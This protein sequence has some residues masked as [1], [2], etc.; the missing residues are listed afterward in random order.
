M[1]LYALWIYARNGAPDLPNAMT[2]NTY[3]A[4][5]HRKERKKE[6]TEKPRVGG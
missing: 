3:D 1:I 4:E 2:S 6:S 5:T